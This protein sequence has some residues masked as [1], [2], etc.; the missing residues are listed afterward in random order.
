MGGLISFLTG[1]A[2]R[3][4]WGEVSHWFT[5]KQEHAQEIARMQLQ[6]SID[7][8]KHLRDMD[9]LRL[10]SD[11]GIKEIEAKSE[12]AIE[13]IDTEAWKVAVGSIGT[14]TGVAFID[15]WN[16]SVRPLLATLSIAMVVFEVA[17]LGFALND[18]HREL[19]GAVLGLYVADRSL[20]KRGK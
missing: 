12:A 1:S 9:A 8:A 6:E 4:V 17:A 14:T 18:W 15:A 10:Q 19:V 5:A 7:A 13:Q 3:M 16:Q 20:A 2:F 11:L